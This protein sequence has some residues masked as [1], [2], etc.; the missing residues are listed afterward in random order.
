MRRLLLTAV[1]MTATTG[2]LAAI[3]AEVTI[4]SG[5]IA[6]MTDAEIR[7]FK[8]IPFAAPPVGPNRWRAPQP[9]ARWS[10]VRAATEYAPRCTQGG[11][12]GPNATAPPTG[13]DC[14]YLN[15]WRAK[16]P[17]SSR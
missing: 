2:A 4:D 8:G 17:S 13:E 10:E 11:A 1:S 12:G 7:V 6:G 14:L 3:P 5:T 16:A 15:V 9:V